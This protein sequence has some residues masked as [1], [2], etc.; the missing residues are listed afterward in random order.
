MPAEGEICLGKRA[1]Y[2]AEQVRYRDRATPQPQRQR[3][4]GAE[5]AAL[6]DRRREGRPPIGGVGQVGHLH[7]CRA[8][9]A[10]Q[11]RALVALQLQ[12]LHH[13]RSLV[14]GGD[15]AQLAAGIA[16]HDAGSVGR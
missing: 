8:L 13:V 16:Q 6:G 1:R 7:R 14:G 4:Y 9:E 11:A 2:C 5:V 15:R 12:Q 10:V 3:M